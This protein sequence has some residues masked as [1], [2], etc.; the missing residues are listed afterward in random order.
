MTHLRPGR[1]QA[2]VAGLSVLTLVALAGPGAALGHAELATV[3]PADRSTIAGPPPEIVLTFTENLDPARSSVRLIDS[4]GG[5]VAEAGTVEPGG[6][7]RTM[8]LALST[9]LAPGTYTVRWTSFST[10][11]N[12]Q[13]RGTTTFT[14]TLTTAPP[15]VAPSAAPPTAP[16]SSAV[17]T[18]APPAAPSPSPAPTTPAA[19]NT[20]VLIPIVAVLAV[21]AGLALWLLRGRSRGGS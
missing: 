5:L 3:S 10:E 9:A 12:E 7:G 15:T 19:S 2:A 16:S 14:V 4:G 18:S 6:D 13:D 17:A 11:D 1:L 21:L 20:D 8:R